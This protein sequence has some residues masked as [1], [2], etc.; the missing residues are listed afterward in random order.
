M[1]DQSF[2]VPPIA[3][4][5]AAYTDCSV[6][7]PAAGE[8]AYAA[9]TTYAAGAEVISATTHRAYRSRQDGNVG[10]PLPV[11][12]AT[13]TEWWRDTGPTLRWAMLDLLS[14]KATTGASPLTLRLTPDAR[15][16]AFGA[17]GVLADSVTLSLKVGGVEKW[18]ATQ[19]LR[20]RVV[21]SWSEWLTTPFD[22]TPDVL[23]MGIPTQIGA[24]LEAT[25]T[26]AAGPVSV[27]QLLIGR[28][29][30]IGDPPAV[31]TP[32]TSDIESFSLVERDEFGTLKWVPRRAV[33][34]ASFTVLADRALGRRLQDARKSLDAK[35]AMWI[36]LEDLTDAYGAALF[37]IGKY[38]RWLMTLNP[39][40]LIVQELE[41]E[42]L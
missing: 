11:W 15:F 1:T 16:T 5:D 38:N 37:S 36:G 6:G 4:D 23:F 10:K 3:I 22:S 2:V 33:A 25:F 39:E 42:G 7:E 14:T 32:A 9:G 19:N 41:I 24:V 18:T 26:R 21:R 17:T 8:T 34:K 30:A 28:A 20:R 35:P 13:Q 29:I 40:G 31:S 27:T 12:P